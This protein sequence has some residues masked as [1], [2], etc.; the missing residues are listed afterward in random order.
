MKAVKNSELL[1]SETPVS[2][3]VPYSHHVTN[4]IISTKTAEYLAVWKIC[5]RSH[6]SASQE[7]VFQWINELNNTLR[8]LA[9]ANLSFWT[10]VVRRRVYEYP[11]STFD[12][13]FC[14]K[15]D[16]KYQCSFSGYNLM[17]NDLYLTVVY[18]PVVDRVMSF[19]DQYESQTLEQKKMHQDS[20]IKALDDINRTLGQSLKRYGA[21]LLGVYEKNGYAFSSSLEFLGMLVNG[22]YYPMPIC[23]DRF[24]DYMVINRPFFSKWGSIGELRTSTG[25]RKFGMIEIREYSDTTKPG[26]L[27]VLLESDFEF[28]LTQSFSV[29]SQ[30]SAK[31][32]LQRHQRNL[33]D[34]RDV[35]TSQIEQ[36]DE[37]LNQLISGRFVMGEHHCTLTIYGDTVQQVRDY[38]A[39]ASA[40]MLDVAVM[41]KPVDLALES[42]YWAQLPGNWSWRPRPAPITSLNFLSFSS[43]HNFMSGKP[44]GNPWGPAVTILK[45]I[46]K[47]PLYFNFH[48]SVLEEDSTDKR[49]LGNTAL[50]GQSGSGKTVLLGFL[51]AQAQKF[52]PTVVVFDKDRGMEIVIR[53][54]G[55]RYLPLKMGKPSGFNPFQLPPTQG[56]LIFLKQFVKKLVEMGG[57]VT[58][59]DEE[60]IN[61]A[62]TAVMSDNMD[63]TL[64]RL[65]LLLQFLPNPRSYDPS[66]R[67]TVHSRLVKWCAN[68]DYG[69]LFDNAVDALDLSTHRIYGFDITEFLDNPETRT[70]VMM[71][72]LYRTEGMISGQR[73][74]YVFDEFWKPLQ[75]P[76]F[77][78]LAKNKQKTIRKQNGIFV[79]ATQ[80]PSD[81]L[82]S[83]I[84]KTLI[85]QCAT[86]VF[87]ANPKADYEDY[88]KGFKL[89][90]TEFELIK[91]LGEFSRQFLI[92]QDDQSAIAELS[93]GKFN[94]VIDGEVHEQNFD[95]EL[96]VL[97][98]TPDNAELVETIISE[99]GDDP[100]VWLPIFL[101]YKREEKNRIGH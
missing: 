71:Y 76:Y 83:S 4:T 26:Q 94:V 36:I 44:A 62:V 1:L 88:T 9:S 3:F 67:P 39:K 33:I 27:N 97:S 29:L 89:T 23:H 48:S 45:T 93:L 57:E 54:M 52:K 15:L 96:L 17:V 20:C 35:A 55:G 68:G 77:E 21:E 59:H 11:A 101:Q 8:G 87:L 100:A 75:D 18:R 58:H 53:A 30:H 6:Q 56:N 79:F 12:G 92:K 95:D 82:E 7:D 31:D 98:G 63:K 32:Y 22:E 51:L 86:Y 69:W 34:A 60:E 19:F 64:R 41:P 66:T 43:F 47:T 78:D 84:A 65:S 38:T 90:D 61:Q 91:G 85:Q 24:A 10:H 2:T 40:A 37:A 13:A 74:M 80:E 99:V 73:F 28:I 49:L 5:G 14:R 25:M 16:E 81:A 70:P 72:L 50:I 42:G 46:S